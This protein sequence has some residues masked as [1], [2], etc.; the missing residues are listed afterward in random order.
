[1]LPYTRSEAKAWARETFHGACNV[2]I[3]SYTA[4]LR[5]L[6]EAGIRHDVRRNV[7]LG[8][9][10]AL[11]VSEAGTTHAEMRRFME[12]AVDEARGRQRFLL[13][14][15]FDTETDI[16]TMARDAAAIGVDGM[17]L[18]HPN[19]F[20]PATAGELEAYTTRICEA[21]DLA[22][23]LFVVEHSN[24]RR[25]DV[26]GFPAGVL[27]R[28]TCLDTVVAVKYE[29]GREQP[30]NTYETFHRLRDAEV[31]LSD[32][33][34][35]NAPMWA[36]VFGMQW[37]GTSN[38]E[39]YGDYVPQLMRLLA[40]GM[41]EEAMDLYWSIDP[42]RRARKTTMNTGGANFV[43]RYL[44]KFQAWLNG[45]N[46]GPLRQPAMKLSEHQMRISAEGLRRAGIAV[47]DDDFASFFVG[48]NPA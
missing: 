33:M 25:L 41:T 48:R 46:G 27:D 21:T 18:G 31:L 24:L 11:L 36:D 43:H 44:W 14:G 22:T 19:S 45:Y 7:E 10:G 2:I 3:P 16:V 1:M 28:L 42:A 5:D 39:Y 8:F 34:E 4:D 29:V 30:A 13:Q 37:I 26:R 17:L 20:H 6:N 32:P 15:V 23:V 38:Y 35:F 40:D 9:W 12:I 47:A